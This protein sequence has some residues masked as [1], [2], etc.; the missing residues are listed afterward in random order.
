M[1]IEVAIHVTLEKKARQMGLS[2]AQ[3]AVAQ[4]LA[5]HPDSSLQEVYSRL[6]WPKSTVSRLVTELT[7]MKVVTRDV[8]LKDKRTVVLSLC[9]STQNECLV[10][11]MTDFFPGSGGK[12]LGKEV[13]EI[14]S[15]LDR[16][17][18]L[19]RK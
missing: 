7:E 3:M 14:V 15:T 4:D 10:N 16:I 5:N 17:L 8:S 18:C 19:M 2:A 1:E 11:V 12:L 13:G 6:G 9:P